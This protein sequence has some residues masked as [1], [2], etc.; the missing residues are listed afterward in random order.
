MNLGF[1]EKIGARFASSAKQQVQ[2]EV[3]AEIDDKIKVGFAV[4]GTVVMTFAIIKGLFFHKKPVVKPSSG[5]LDL[6][7][8]AAAK[9]TK[10]FI[11]N[12]YYYNKEAP[13]E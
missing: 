9:E 11:Q 3:Q 1:V 2:T 7:L 13:I 12:N 4:A 5:V 10:I 8:G 6:G